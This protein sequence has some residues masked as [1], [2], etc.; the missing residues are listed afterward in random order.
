VH[1]QSVSLPQPIILE[2]FD[3]VNE[4]GL[5]TGW[6][7]TNYSSISQQNIAYQDLNS[8]PY[9]G[10][11]VIDSSRFRSNFVG[12]S[13]HTPVD[14][15]R[16]L[17][18]N[19]NNIVNG[20]ALTNLASG[21]I[22]FSN[23]GYREGNQV[24]YLVTRD[25]DLVGRTN[26][27]VSFHSLWEQNQDSFAAIEYS[28]DKG[29][30]W[31]PISYYIDGDDLIKTGGIVDAT[32]TLTNRHADVAVYTEPGTGVLRGGYFGAFI[33]A[34]VGQALA[35]FI[36]ARI[37]DD[38][39]E[40]KRVELYRLPS[41]DNRPS[42]RFR[43]AHAGADSWYWGIDEFGLYSI[44]LGQMPVIL[45][46][47]ADVILTEGL[48]ANF[49][50]QTQGSG[51]FSFQWRIDGA[52]IP[53]ATNSSLA[54]S[55]VS[56]KDQGLYTVLVSNGYGTVESPPAK[57]LLREANITGQWDFDHG[58]LR[59]TVGLDM[60]F[61]ADT[62]APA[63]F[64]VMEINGEQARVLAFGSSF[65]AQ[66]FSMQHGTAPN[67]GGDF[68]NRYTLL[69]DVMYPEGSDGKS[70]PLLQTDPFNHENNDAEFY[71]A[72]RGVPPNGDGIGAEGQYDGQMLPGKWYR[73]AFAVDLAAPP[74][75]EL[76][77]YID[78]VQVGTQA[79]PGGLDGRYS[80]GTSALLFISGPRTNSFTHPGY[81]NSIQFV[82]T[83]LPAETIARLGGP[84]AGGL[85]PGSAV[86][87]IS[88]LVKDGLLTLEWLA[89]PGFFE[90][91]KSGSL[92]DA[93][94]QVIAG[95]SSN[96]S[97]TLPLQDETAF[98]RVRRS[99]IDFQVGPLPDEKQGL[100][101]KQLLRAPGSQ[102]QFA[103]RPV[104]LA[105]SPDHRTVYLKN[106]N[107]LV[108]V[109]MESWTVRQHLSY[110]TNGASLHGIAVTK[111]GSRVYVT[112]AV[113]E[114]YEWSV[115][116]NGVVSFSRTI[117]M[118]AN[119]YPC[120]LALSSGGDKAF[121]CLSIAN[122]LAVVDLSAGTIRSQIRVGVAPWDVVL[123]PDE[124]T[125]WVSDWGGRFPVAGDLSA[126]SAGTQVV[127]DERGVGASG[128]VSAVNIMTA[129][130]TAQVPT[131]LHPSDLELSPDGATLYVANANSDT[132]TV[133]DTQKLMAKE[134]ILV[135][136][137]ARFPHG[138][139]VNGLALGEGGRTLY[140]A[141][142][143]NNS[144]AVIQLADDSTNASVV[145]G[146]IPTDW[147]PGAVAVDKGHLYVANVKGLGTRLGQPQ[148][149]AWQIGAHLGTA[150]KIPF[151]DAESLAKY[152]SQAH[153]QG[154][155][156]HIR[157][158]FRPSRG[159]MQ[160]VPVPARVGEPSIFE[161]V[162]YIV[163][164]NKTYD[165]LFGDMPEGNGE[166]TLC[167]YP[168][169]VT[170]NHHALA[171][172]YVLLDNFYCNGVNSA[173]GHAWS[174]EGNVS[175]YLE[176]SFGGFTR[177]YPFGDDALSYSSTGFIWNNVL[178]HGLTFR[179]YG[180]MDYASTFPEASWMQIY[181]DF[182][183]GTRSIHYVQN[184][185]IASLVPYSSTNVPGWNLGIPDIV[186]ADGFIQD[187]KASE[188]AG[189]WAGFHLLYLPNDHTG[190][191]PS[192]RAQVADN[193]L[194]L[195]LVVEAVTK[196]IFG[197]KTVIFVIEDD[198][199]S[200]YD[201]VD[202]HRSICLIISPYTKRGKV[203]SNFYNQAG[204][205]HTMQRIL[206]IPPLNQQ[207]AMAPLMFE[208]FTQVGDFTPYTALTNNI[209]LAEGTSGTGSLTPTQ[210]HWAEKARKMD[211]SKPDRIKDDTL[212]R[213]IWHS[214]MGD[215]QYPAEF[216]GGHG[217]GLK[218]LGLQLVQEEAENEDNTES[219]D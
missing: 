162:L 215:A 213:Y 167:I 219:P 195:G 187:L 1:A 180:E 130:E 170:P 210:R 188:A 18:L 41:A 19:P 93:N 204:V 120:G 74:G 28:I 103:G 128:V 24:M 207:D 65:P 102:I 78:G 168:E 164:E 133:I 199:Q 61:L 165:Q 69:M 217:Q 146:F 172:Q 158:A 17:S 27:H 144:V 135:R 150:N 119:S 73:I 57:L 88:S 56:A 109:D 112:G 147:Y 200:G 105:I 95:P 139:A 148:V 3:N 100:P 10:W 42:V 97:I 13:V 110:P 134:T 49:S 4:G 179:N 31:L 171:R 113:N 51:P 116:T 104:D 160:A 58:D 126:L 106:I 22:L 166:P 194:S 8:L 35:P 6:I 92:L 83:C 218:A 201:H 152:T 45:I 193:D 98:Y 29:T 123:S 185:G 89:N 189:T 67:A 203:I 66:G 163:K 196:S 33:G 151:P 11:L 138:S 214:I 169:L 20:R 34:P 211:F 205:L 182:T 40:S 43:F 173:D 216:V 84:D 63:S 197:P 181:R 161:H 129:L 156:P 145:S 82:D 159:E 46:A 190:G 15:S 70:L 60:E 77:K 137:D 85:P 212:N 191:P 111:D 117:A 131:G 54:L 186:R 142:G 72:A 38:P 9:A 154:R 198:P 107:S 127:V 80:L 16:V 44:T 39:V 101:S 149:A 23:S 14:Y 174:T 87:R 99:I 30:N 32:K 75:Q 178:R 59:A 124:T 114:L 26:V 140:A 90:V 202:G 50:V 184:I 118:P 47:P 94:W 141:V 5:P 206:G 121:V 81:V 37:N 208:C 52:D 91:E 76:T 62:S 108:V 177:S 79:L 132:V 175:D 48:T 55:T 25:Y 64:P 71:I 192:P 86:I 157:N 53:G 2:N 115:G 122:K 21:R 209:P 68:V 183:N 153:E 125:A 143:G 36:S 176:K 12:Y 7:G 96:Q 155:V 136:P